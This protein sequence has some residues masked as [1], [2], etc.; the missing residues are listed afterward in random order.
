MQ[1]YETRVVALSRDEAQRYHSSEP[2]VVISLSDSDAP[3]PNIYRHE[4]LRDWLAL[5]F[6]DVYP[7]HCFDESGARLFCEMSERDAHRI[8]E[9]VHRW[10]GEVATIVVHCHAGLS[11]S[12]GVAAAI[13]T[14]H[15]QDERDLYESPRNPN[16]HCLALVREALRVSSSRH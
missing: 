12:T 5:H 14:H 9:F 15:G 4:T 10:W 16:R 7:Q 6:D 8:A 1:M 2:Y 13:R 11:R 3:P